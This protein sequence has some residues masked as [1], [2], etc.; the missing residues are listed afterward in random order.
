MTQ[1]ILVVAEV[2]FERCTGQ[3]NIFTNLG[4]GYIQTLDISL[5]RSRSEDMVDNIL[6]DAVNTVQ[7]SRDV[8][9]MVFAT[10][11]TIGNVAAIIGAGMTS[12]SMWCE[13]SYLIS[14]NDKC[15]VIICG[16][17]RNGNAGYL[18]C[19][20]STGGN[21]WYVTGHSIYDY[22]NS[23]FIICDSGSEIIGYIICDAGP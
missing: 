10:G 21:I 3:S 23:L 2:M 7:G 14:V 15:S 12:G 1:Y 17:R 4:C 22:D 20:A 18:F 11:P 5:I 9:A 19:I 8:M 6:V 16:G 13:S